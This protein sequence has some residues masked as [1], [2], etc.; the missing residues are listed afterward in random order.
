MVASGANGF[1]NTNPNT[2]AGANFDFHPE[3]D[4][5]KF[6][7][8]VYWAALQANIN[9]AVEIGHFEALDNDADDPPCFTGPGIAG[10]LGADF[11][12][13][14]S[15]YQTGWPGSA[16]KASGSFQIGSVNGHGAG[17]L[18]ISDGTGAYDQP[19][20]IIQLETDVS[21]SEST[22]QPNGVGCVVPP[23]GAAFYPFYAFN[24]NSGQ[25]NGVCTLVFGNFT[26][27]V[28]NFGGDAQYGAPN[29]AWFFGT[30]SSG[31]MT[32]PC[33]PKT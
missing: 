18:S 30:N 11:D 5:A 33:I 3:Y 15:S 20:S 2:C 6:G 31:P 19:Y 25:G 27:G 10:C 7:N 14:G 13:D 17:P 8:F 26:K 16:K 12:F 28:N 23:V 29:L 1:Q 4:T 9:F 32:N 22:C 21:S 24:T